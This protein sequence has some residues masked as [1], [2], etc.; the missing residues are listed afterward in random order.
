MARQKI[1]IGLEHTRVFSYSDAVIVKVHD[2]S[3]DIELSDGTR[4]NYVENASSRTF[5]SGDFVSTIFLNREK[6][7]CRIVGT[8]RQLTRSGRIPEVLV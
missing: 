6:T 4:K 8:G 7:D 3:Y 5:R 1:I 2:G